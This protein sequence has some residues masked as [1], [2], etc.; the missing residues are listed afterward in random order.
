MSDVYARSLF[1]QKEGFPLHS[2]QPFSDLPVP[3]R[4]TGT[5]IGDVGTITTEGCFEPIFNILRP[6]NDYANRFG[7]PTN[8]EQATLRTGD[9]RTRECCHPPGA[10]ISNNTA[11]RQ[12][13]KL[14]SIEA[15]A[16]VQISTA[17]KDTAALILP[18]GAS[19]SDAR[20]ERMLHKYAEKHARHWYAF[21]RNDLRRIVS[22]GGLYLIT[23][24][25]KSTSWCIAVTGASSGGGELSL[26]LKAAEVGGV[27]ATRTWEWETSTGSVHSGPHHRPGE[28]AWR[29]NQTLFVRGF[30]VALGPLPFWKPK[31]KSIVQCKVDDLLAA[32]APT[33]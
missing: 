33:V 5:E 9:I 23:G 29:D 17:S 6:A 1:S 10:V 3:A 21:V 14:F 7:V 22:D 26:Q 19:K 11:S 16:K 2:P 4:R 32:A 12:T 24:V 31:V 30:R 15:D 8:F 13:R 18:H 28:E 27:G 25:T 20:P